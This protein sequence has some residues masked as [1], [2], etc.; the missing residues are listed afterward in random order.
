[1]TQMKRMT[2]TLTAEQ[3]RRIVEMRKTDEFCQCSIAEIIR[4]LLERA[5][6]ESS[7]TA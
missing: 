6:P 5:L 1:M 7:K 4:T 2:V 3:K